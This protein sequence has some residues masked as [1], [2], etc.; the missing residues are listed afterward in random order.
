MTP[1]LLAALVRANLAAAVAVVAVLILRAPV[2]RLF[3]AHVA[4]GL[5]A[6]TPLAYVG[7]LLPARTDPNLA[8]SVTDQAAPSFGPGL[9]AL[10][11]A[12]VVLSLIGLALGQAMFLRRERAGTAGPAIVGVICPRLVVPRD[13]HQSFTPEERTLIRTHERVHVE[14]GDLR[15]NA[16]IVLAQCLNWFNPFVHL[17]AHLARQDQELACDAT[18][19]ARAPKTRRLYAETL[20]KTQMAATALP[21]G[22][23]W[24]AGSRHPL[25]TRVAMLKAPP[26]APSRRRLGVWTVGVVAAACAA[27]AWAAQPPTPPEPDPPVA[28]RQV[29]LNI[30][31]NP[32]PVPVYL[33][34]RS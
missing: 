20:L 1:D 16:L 19:V 28:P 26:P 33:P 23:R 5:W 15:V 10:W 6:A 34:P 30:Q 3:G 24:S 12:G 8:V 4:Y 7:S 31:I 11:L 13:F 21:L 22:C 9:A 14:R 32:N 17:A 29:Q 25:E 27:S 18:V 2:R